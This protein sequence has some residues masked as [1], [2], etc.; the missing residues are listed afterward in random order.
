VKQGRFAEATE[1]A[2]ALLAGAQAAGRGDTVDAAE[3]IDVLV[4]ALWRDGKAAEPQ[5]LALA[6]RAVGIK[7]RTLGPEDPRLAASLS[8]QAAVLYRKGEYAAA[9]AVYDRILGIREKALGTEHADVAATVNNL[10]NIALA[11]GDYAAARSLYERALA[12]REKVLGPRTPEVAGTLYNLGI[13]AYSTGDYEASQS[14]YE[15]AL[16]VNEALLGPD[17]LEVA[18]ILNGF[19]LAVQESGDYARARAMLERCL[20]IREKRLGPEH[21][22]LGNS[23]ANLAIL[24][25]DTGDYEKAKPLLAR[26]HAILAKALG[27]DHPDVAQSYLNQASLLSLMGDYAAARPLY[28]RSNALWEKALGVDHPYVALGL[29][30]LAQL[31]VKTGEYERARPL[32]ERGLAIAEKRLG[33]GHPQIASQLTTLGSIREAT[34]DAAGARRLHERALGIREAVFGPDHTEVAETL[35]NLARLDVGRGR[36][37]DGLDEAL[38][39]ESIARRQFQRI[40]RSLAESEALR[41]EAIRASGLGVALSTL[42]SGGPGGRPAGG[43]GRVWDELVRSR[44]LVLDEMA[45]RHRSLP[46]GEAEEVAPLAASLER[47]RARLA[48]EVVKGPDPERPA[49]YRERLAR[50]RDEEETAERALAERSASFRQARAHREVGLGEVAGA[51]PPGT[52]LV[53]YVQFDRQSPA[54]APARGAKPAPPV[55]SYLAMV[56]APGEREPVAVDLGPARTVDDLIQRWRHAAGSG[57]RGL[58]VAGGRAEASYQEVARPLRRAIWDPVEKRLGDARAVFVV[59]D[60]AMH[61]V[62]LG[63]LPAA[64]GRFLVESGPLLH[65]LSAERDLVRDPPPE[66][67]AGG[68][69]VVGGPDFDSRS[70]AAAGTLLAASAAREGAGP[71]ARGAHYRGPRSA[72]ADFRSLRFQ[73][74]PGARQEADEVVSLWDAG[75]GPDPGKEVLKLV[76]PDAGEAAFKE[77]V[78][79]RRIVHVATHGFFVD[80]GCGPRAGRTRGGAAGAPASS[81]SP[82]VLSGLALAGANRRD[83][84]DPE[85]DAEDGILT[86]EE[87]ASLD[88]SAAEWVV[89]SACETG[90]GRVQTGEGVLGLRRAFE[91]AGA[92]TLVMSLWPVDDAAARGWMR[93]LYETRLRGLTTSEAM[94]QA[95]LETIR[96]RRR[97]GR[98][99]HPFY[100][101]AFVAA[102]DWR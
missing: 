66:A 82:L 99:T 44:A 85:S 94:R 90:V 81:E 25:E 63:T 76:G 98:S 100:W 50:L 62:S 1:A 92:R 69:V 49:A 38:H 87:I 23:L 15:R 46:S 37:E 3:V 29:N 47:A 7:E 21:P 45:R 31:L 55:P 58:D 53:A 56:L 93:R 34:G 13:V 6:K 28:E 68:V 12:I 30:E 16:A 97:A 10:A 43:G 70:D 26:A 22:L 48:R 96:A 17:H 54:A 51:L 42:V 2:R 5:T 75:P 20:A 88:L 60:G 67:G 72:C 71:V 86:G 36:A 41:Y 80:G 9:K 18:D 101:G 84:I 74:L 14:F 73:P 79:G 33:A 8:G 77:A 52:A 24:F 39:A 59:P 102:G 89:L 27:A 57:P 11:T 19:G 40:S 61:L 91:V 32:C 35:V 65:Y 78:A 83:E 4:D 95:S 64:D